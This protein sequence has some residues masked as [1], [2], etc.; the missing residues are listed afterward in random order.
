MNTI[1][2][3][4]LKSVTGVPKKFKKQTIFSTQFRKMI[5]KDLYNRGIIT[6][7]KAKGFAEKYNTLVESYMQVLEQIYSDNSIVRYELIG[8]SLSTLYSNGRIDQETVPADY[9]ELRVQ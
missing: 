5:L 7:P 1:Y 9:L 6:D 2:V 4:Y 8:D 3:E